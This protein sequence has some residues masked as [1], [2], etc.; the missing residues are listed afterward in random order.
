EVVEWVSQG[1]RQLYTHLYKATTQPPV[2]TLTI[3]HGLGEHIDRY[4]S[5]A[6]TFAHAGIQA[7]GF[8]QRGFGKTGRKCGRLG[9]NEG[10][11]AVC[12]D[13]ALMNKRVAIDGVP[14]FLLGHSMGGL[15]VLNYALGHNSDGHIR[16]VIASAPALLPGRPLLPPRFVMSMLHSVARV[17]P[18]I[19]KNT[20]I[21][22]DMLT[23]NKTE[24]D[25]FNAS[26]E[27]IGHCT[28][29]TL[30]CVL[31]RGP[32]VLKHA[33]EFATP[34]YL[35]HAIG[36]KATDYEGTRQF[37][38]GLPESLDKEYNEVDR[39]YHELHFEEDM[40]PELVNTYKQ[41]MLDRLN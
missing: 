13:I 11:D 34:V 8:D 16:G 28:L 2:A 35:V 24:I 6:R 22:A 26:I 10:I 37:F 39:N 32:Y 25:K 19:Q 38:H 40:G 1:K 7:I 12:A 27:N 15:N 17:V 21:T 3:V 29:G 33:S 4:E 31:R 41:W 9:D 20:G 30:S 23:S 14:H 18:S 5:M 36:D